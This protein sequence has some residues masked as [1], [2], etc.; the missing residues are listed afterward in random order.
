MLTCLQSGL[1][2]PAVVVGLAHRSQYSVTRSVACHAKVGLVQD[3]QVHHETT[4]HDAAC[5]AF[6]RFLSTR[7]VVMIVAQSATIRLLAACLAA[8][9]WICLPL[10]VVA[11]LYEAGEF[12]TPQLLSCKENELGLRQWLEEKVRRSLTSTTG[13][14]TGMKLSSLTIIKTQCNFAGSRVCCSGRQGW[15]R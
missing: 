9:S 1:H 5:A 15:P 2:T 14:V 8:P 3:A 13:D 6:Q 4:R 11:V 10:Q 12:V 7:C